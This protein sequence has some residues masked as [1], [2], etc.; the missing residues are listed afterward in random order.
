[1]DLAY[2]LDRLCG[3]SYE[4]DP[5]LAPT[6]ELL[7][8]YRRQKRGWSA[9]EAAFLR[10]M[11]ERGIPETLDRATFTRRTAILCSEATAERCHRRLVAELLAQHWGATLEHL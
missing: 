4:H 3:I 2:F 5:R 10:L 8:G 6:E 11:A 1:P 7:A 9:Y